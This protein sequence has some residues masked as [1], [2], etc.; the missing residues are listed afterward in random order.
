MTFE[1]KKI[2]RLEK[3]KYTFRFKNLERNIRNIDILAI[4]PESMDPQVVQLID[5]N[6]IPSEE[7]AMEAMSEACEVA[8]KFLE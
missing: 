6:Y 7:E 4:C 2:E 3:Q 8:F 1:H 5:E